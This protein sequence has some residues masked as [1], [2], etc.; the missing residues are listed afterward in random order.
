M[1]NSENGLGKKRR[2]VIGRATSE[3]MMHLN[4][5]F[6]YLY[7]ALWTEYYGDQNLPEHE[8][9]VGMYGLSLGIGYSTNLYP[10]RQEVYGP[11][12]SNAIMDYAMYSIM[13]QTD[14]TQLFHDQMPR[15]VPY[16][17]EA[18]SD[19]WYS[20]LFCTYMSED[21]NHRFRTEWLKEN[22]PAAVL[23]KLGSVLMVRTMTVRSK[24]AVSVKKGTQN[25]I[26]I[27]ILSA[28]FGSSGIVISRNWPKALSCAA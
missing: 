1:I 17:K 16:S 11:L 25:H 4:D 8:L 9:H 24:A 6:R 27:L 19:S 13:D 2:K 26:P 5:L 18:Y 20:N 10:I 23:Q 28:L 21:Y 3:S 22:A 12:Y 14:T 15:E 7:P